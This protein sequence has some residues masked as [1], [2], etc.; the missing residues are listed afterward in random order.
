MELLSIAQKYDMNPALA[1]IRGAVALQEPPFICPENAFQVYSLAQ[2]YGL[3]QEF[4]QAARMALTFPTI[5]DLEDK[6]DTISG[7]HLHILWKYID[8]HIQV[9]HEPTKSR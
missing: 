8:Y 7:A 4:V 3:C 5:E 2:R 9:G 1:R 6:Y